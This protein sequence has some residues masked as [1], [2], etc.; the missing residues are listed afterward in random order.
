MNRSD[1]LA[2]EGTELWV[3]LGYI[4][5]NVIFH[6]NSRELGTRDTNVL[7][8]RA[9]AVTIKR[10]KLEGCYGSCV[11]PDA[12]SDRVR[13]HRRILGDEQ[14]DSGS[15][16]SL[17]LSTVRGACGKFRVYSTKYLIK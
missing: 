2:R 8:K 3:I 15:G 13:S 5:K 12:C 1:I 11:D 17:R 9:N 16:K 7:C 14:N 10:L 4:S 6:G